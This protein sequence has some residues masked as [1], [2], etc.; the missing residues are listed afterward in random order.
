ME[1]WP[2]ESPKGQSSTWLCTVE[3]STLV[4]LSYSGDGMEPWFEY[5][6]AKVG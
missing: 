6:L 1:I 3:P 4:G 5:R 2:S